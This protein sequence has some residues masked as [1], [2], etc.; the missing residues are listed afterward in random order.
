MKGGELPVSGGVQVGL[1]HARSSGWCPGADHRASRRPLS[2]CRGGPGPGASAAP[3]GRGGGCY[4]CPVSAA[5]AARRGRGRPRRHIPSR[6]PAPRRA[7]TMSTAAFHISSLLE[8]MTSSDKDFRCVS[9]PGPQ[10]LRLPLKPGPSSPPVAPAHPPRACSP[11]PSPRVKL[12]PS[13]DPRVRHPCFPVSLVAALPFLQSQLHLPPCALRPLPPSPGRRSPGSA[14]LHLSSASSPLAQPSSLPVADAPRPPASTHGEALSPFLGI[15]APA[16][17]SWHWNSV[18]CR[19]HDPGN[20][21]SMDTLSTALFSSESSQASSLH[22][23]RAS[24]LLPS[25]SRLALTQ[26]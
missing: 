15:P 14:P 10:S 7:A 16:S 1:G 25:P 21:F 26:L 2:A 4:F 6:R 24:S 9:L 12:H 3:P 11:C 5:R 19:A 22:F 13:P 20:D 8:K 23:I 18:P 17:S